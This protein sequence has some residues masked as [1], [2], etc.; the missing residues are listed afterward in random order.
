M[1]MYIDMFYLAWIFSS[2]ISEVQVEELVPH[3]LPR[4]TPHDIW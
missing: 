3:R 2:V 1:Y 4:Y